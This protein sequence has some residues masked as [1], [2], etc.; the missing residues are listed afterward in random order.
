MQHC[1]RSRSSSFRPRKIP[2]RRLEEPEDDIIE[3]P[4]ASRSRRIAR[5][6]ATGSSIRASRLN[7]K[8]QGSDKGKQRVKRQD[9]EARILVEGSTD[10]DEDEDEPVFVGKSLAR[11]YTFKSGS[12]VKSD[13]SSSSSIV[14]TDEVKPRAKLKPKGKPKLEDQKDPKPQPPPLPL[15][16]PVENVRAPPVPAWLGKTSILL[17]IPYCVVCKVR[18]KKENGAARWVSRQS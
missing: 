3:G 7:S 17:Q 6:A 13:T 14:V 5:K 1:S 8:T 2:D 15:V 10:E 18:W 12:I 4:A 16:T 9:P 11:K